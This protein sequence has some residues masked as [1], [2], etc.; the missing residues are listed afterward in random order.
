MNNNRYLTFALLFTSIFAVGVIIWY[1]FFATPKT[2]TTLS[3][4]SNPLVTQTVPS[5]FGFITN[6]FTGEQPVSTTTTE[7]TP[8]KDQAFVKIW[9]KPSTG[10]T[11]VYISNINTITSTSSKIIKKVPTVVA[12][13]KLVYSTSTI[14]MFV[15]RT[16][17]YIYGHS[18]ETGNTY[19]ISNTLIPGVHD[20]Y[21]FNNGK[22]ILLRSLGDDKKTITSTLADVPQTKEGAD[23]TPLLNETSLPV[24]IKSVVVSASSKK[25]SYLVASSNSSSIYTI[26]SKGT[27]LTAF[28][29]FNELTLSYGGEQLFATS[30]P[31]AYIEG[32]TYVLPSFTRIIGNKTGLMSNPSP[33]GFLINNMWSNTGL[34]SFL[35][36][37]KGETKVLDI[38]TLASKCSWGNLSTLVCAIP[39]SIGQTSEGL[40]DDWYQGVIKFSDSL[41]YISARTDRK[42]VV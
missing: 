40:P 34:L 4:T 19:Q 15:D 38:K 10:N 33:D 24:N 11:F 21:I 18:Q 17:G 7:V 20:A 26:I 41:F 36:S 30:K 37:N 14:L 29:P 42:S 35:F 32:S 6:L 39:Q 5:R 23:P 28:S 2:A 25:I 31:S 13:N 12:V 1:F 22:Q 8:L 27:E 3:T 16:T 9:D